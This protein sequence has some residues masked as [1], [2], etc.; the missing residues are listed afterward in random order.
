MNQL[1]S[2]SSEVCSV[3]KQLAS[4]LQ[5]HRSADNC[6]AGCV[7]IDGVVQA[8]NVRLSYIDE[9]F[10]DAHTILDKS[11]CNRLRCNCGYSS[12]FQSKVI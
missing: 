10:A 6:L 4:G 1:Q 7:Y 8:V 2:T 3:S 5:A 9:L 12:T 11:V